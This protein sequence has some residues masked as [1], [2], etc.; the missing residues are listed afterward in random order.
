MQIVDLCQILR[1]EAFLRTIGE[2]VG[3]VVAVDFSEAYR[4]KL[5]GPRVRL[6]V[7]DLS[8]LPQ[9]VIVPRL[10]GEGV[11][12]YNLELC[13]FP[14][15]CG[16]CRAHDHQVRHCPRKDN[17]S[18]H[19]ATAHS[20]PQPHWRRLP[21]GT[22]TPQPA[23][24]Q[25]YRNP[26]EMAPQATEKEPQLESNAQ[27]NNTTATATEIEPA[28]GRS[29]PQNNTLEPRQ[30]TAIPQDVPMPTEPLLDPN[31]D[32]PT[33]PSTTEHTLL[34]NNENFPQLQTPTQATPIKTPPHRRTPETIPTTNTFVWR[35]KHNVG[36]TSIDKGKQKAKTTESAPLTRQGYRSGQLAEDFWLALG[37]PNIPQTSKK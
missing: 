12:E 33:S 36:E 1:D 5:F 29:S 34:P 18:K 20:H 3:Q 2:Q 32:E 17:K 35:M 16:R 30:K 6:L 28:E 25:P 8:T 15:Q 4:A 37:M 27:L 23:S 24:P 21:L 26:T 31:I 13:G 9:T 19:N 7:R 11:V 14:N 10:D 22:T